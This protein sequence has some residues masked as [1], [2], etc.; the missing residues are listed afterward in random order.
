MLSEFVNID[1]EVVG[2]IILRK[3][4]TQQGCTEHCLTNACASCID[5]YW[6]LEESKE[7]HRQNCVSGG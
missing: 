5:E 7:F 4:A 2:G 6:K 1:A 3:V